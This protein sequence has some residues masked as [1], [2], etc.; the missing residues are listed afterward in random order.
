MVVV[1]VVMVV[2]VGGNGVDVGV[3]SADVGNYAAGVF[4]VGMLLS[5]LC[6]CCCYCCYCRL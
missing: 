1:V 4:G 6:R 5:F 2:A 3:V